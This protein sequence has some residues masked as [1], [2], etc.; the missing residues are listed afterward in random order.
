ME[1]KFLAIPDQLSRFHWQ[2]S[3]SFHPICVYHVHLWLKISYADA[4]GRNLHLALRRQTGQK[5]RVTVATLT[6]NRNHDLHAMGSTHPVG[7]ILSSGDLENLWLARFIRKILHPLG[8]GTDPSGINLTL[9]HLLDEALKS[10]GRKVEDFDVPPD[11]TNDPTAARYCPRCHSMYLAEVKTCPD[12]NGLPL[13][14]LS[15]D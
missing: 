9:R 12:C 2:L 13:R 15:V 4:S 14:D 11:R 6:D 1:E 8:C 10:S 5:P 7:L 3:H